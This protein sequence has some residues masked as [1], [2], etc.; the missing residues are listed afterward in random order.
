MDTQ[1]SDTDF[2]ST[3]HT[4]HSTMAMRRLGEI[5][6]LPEVLLQRIGA[7]I[8]YCNFVESQAER[9]LWVLRHEDVQGK[10]PSTSKYRARQLITELRKVAVNQEASVA[11]AIELACDTAL[12][13][14]EYRN[15]IAHGELLA[16]GNNARFVSNAGL[17][18]EVKKRPDATALISEPFLDTAIDAAQTAYYAM[19][20]IALEAS[21]PGAG[22]PGAMADS[23]GKL[24][25]VRSSMSELCRSEVLR[26]FHEMG[27]LGES[28]P[29]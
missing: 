14:A 16:F 18:G 21:G 2:P 12:D 17:W 8:V 4:L 10:E 25:L 6:G 1:Q 23:L 13:V 19:Y 20:R 7:L 29:A 15:C 9:T 11:E 24:N 28:E 27:N 22:R 26:Y 5:N 3:P